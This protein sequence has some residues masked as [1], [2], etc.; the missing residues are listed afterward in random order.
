ML[1]NRFLDCAAKG[2]RPRRLEIETNVHGFRRLAL[3]KHFELFRAFEEIRIWACV[4]SA[5]MIKARDWH[6]KD[7]YCWV[8]A[9]EACREHMAYLLKRMRAEVGD[10]Q[11]VEREVRSGGRRRGPDVRIEVVVTPRIVEA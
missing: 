6:A 2:A 7:S 1:L 3:V 5:D 11:V 10:V 8:T 4:Y 9:P